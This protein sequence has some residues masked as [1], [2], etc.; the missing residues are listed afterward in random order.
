MDYY[1]GVD[2][3]TTAVKV[4]AFSESGEVLSQQSKGYEMLHPEPDQSEQDP[5]EIV[6]ATIE[7]IN[8]MYDALIPAKPIL[9][10]F[11]AA[12]H[13]LLALD[14]KGNPLTNCI[15]WADNRAIG[16]AEKLKGSEQ[17]IEFYHTG[18][19]AIHAMSPLCKLL[20][21]KEKSPVVFNKTYKFLGIKEYFI[22]KITGQYITDKAVASA[23]GLFNLQTLHWNEAALNYIG[24]TEDKL[25]L[26]VS[27]KN[28]ISFEKKTDTT[29][30]LHLPD[31]IIL[32]TGASDGAAANFS[33]G[34]N[35]KNKMV[36]TIGTSSAIRIVTNEPYTDP[37]MRTFCYHAKDGEYIAG[38]AGN[39]GAVV[40]EWLKDG[41]LQS[42][43]TMDDFLN[44]AENIP[45]G[46]DGLLLLPYILGERA[47]IW[48]GNAKGV[49][50]GLTVNNTKAHMVRAALEA[51]IYSMFNIGKAL[52]E[53]N[54]VTEIYATGGFSRN[55]LWVQ[56]LADVFNRKVILSGSLESSAWGAVTIGME[57]IGK[58][59]PAMGEPKAIFYPDAGRHEIYSKQFN[60]FER[61]TNLLKDEFKLT[62]K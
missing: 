56:I 28:T 25:P 36:V 2:I 42:T 51:V 48:D 14:E 53:K 40:L 18:G 15:I 43:E 7:C 5:D 33:I 44:L 38:G 20:W 30:K 62:G 50:F 12:M 3:G 59:A 34:S 54:N 1:M 58:T 21:L 31:K 60:R 37:Q 10:S 16:F 49:F 22:Y 41:L 35:Y 55:A 29:S 9:L 4:V 13:S 57:A 45:P 52:L 47:P 19:V 11:S 23:T 27:V 6:Q 61:L 8:K 39:N 46:C 32:V 24:I 26:P 17:G